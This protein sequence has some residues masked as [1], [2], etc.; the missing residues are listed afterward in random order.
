MSLLVGLL[1]LSLQV[2][3]QESRIPITDMIGLSP[4][5]VGALT[6][7]APGVGSGDAVRIVDGDRSVDLYPVRRFWRQPTVENEACL[8]GF[9][10]GPGEGDSPDRRRAL[11]TRTGGLLAFE[12]GRLSGVYPDPPPPQAVS[13]G[14]ATTARDLRA[15]MHAPRPPSPLTVAPGRLPLSD[16][17][18]A[19]TRLEPAAA[20]VA[21]VALCRTVPA[22]TYRSD[23]GM[24]VIWGLVGLTVLPLV[25]FQMAEE[26]R[27]EREGSILL[28]S[29]EAGA[30]LGMSPENWVRGTQGIRVYRDPIDPD[31][32]VIAVRLG[33]GDDTVAKVGLLGVRG[34]R[35]IWKAERA[36]ADQTGL[37]ALVCR[38]PANRSTEA[39]RGCSTT[40]FLIP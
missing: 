3:P 7:A 5:E 9:E 11:A 28:D 10:D 16:G 15:Q 40:G 4:A 27:A 2:A 29:V 26:T 36:A 38:D 37:R 22:R 34:T 23:P 35:V 21:L 24:D 39:R 1:A 8:T 13:T 17:A 14:R 25:P 12:N 32:A 19:M 6:G 20:A 33:S 31:F 18:A 30:D